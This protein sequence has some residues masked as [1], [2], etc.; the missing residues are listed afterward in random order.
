MRDNQRN[1]MYIQAGKKFV[2]LMF[3]GRSRKKTLE[4]VKVTDTSGFGV[5]AMACTLLRN[6]QT[7]AIHENNFIERLD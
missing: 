4:I 6:G 7:Y 5:R 2:V 1:S 3:A